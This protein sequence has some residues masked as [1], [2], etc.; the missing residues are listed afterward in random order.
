MALSGGM[1]LK[2][3]ASVAWQYAF[4]DTTPETQMALLSVPGSNFTVA[5]VPLAENTALI[6]VGTDLAINER[7]SL[8]AS[9][10][11]QFGDSVAVNAVQAKFSWRF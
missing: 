8:G 9:Y 2:P 6:E 4:G 10:V 3:H 1:A 11:G 5:G 7:A